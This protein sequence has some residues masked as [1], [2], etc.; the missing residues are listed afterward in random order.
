MKPLLQV[1]LIAVG[2]GAAGCVTFP[3][4]A[5]DKRVRPGI[6]TIALLQV[7]SPREIEV[8]NIGGAGSAFG[9]L[10]AAVEAS[11][12]ERKTS[13]F[14]AAVR[15]ERSRFG[16]RMMLALKRGLEEGGYR[17]EVLPNVRP[18][19]D[20]EDDQDAD[21]SAIRTNADAI[22]DVYFSRTNFVALGEDYV[23]H[24]MVGARLIATKGRARL[25]AQE[26]RYGGEFGKS[27]DV[28]TIPASQKFRYDSAAELMSR[29]PEAVG[30]LQTGIDLVAERV[31]KALR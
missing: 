18:V 20:D 29:A 8:V 19:K 15:P 12:Q 28:E 4:Q 16:T 22:L 27:D 23:P 13:N 10:G 31:V 30:A 26:Y 5:L 1:A 24:L 17:V 7:E 21:Y 25:F 9:L 2:L 11:E 14:S 3:K 6:Q